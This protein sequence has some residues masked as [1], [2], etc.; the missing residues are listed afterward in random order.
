M[1]L[2][3]ILSKEAVRRFV[4]RGIIGK[5]CTDIQDGTGEDVGT[6]TNTHFKKKKIYF[7][8]YHLNNGH[9]PEKGLSAKVL[10]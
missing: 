8:N 7:L 5:N 4:T 10:F 1:I 2:G 6:G 9:F 3:Y